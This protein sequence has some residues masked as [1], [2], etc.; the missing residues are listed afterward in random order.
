MGWTPRSFTTRA[1]ISL[2][3]NE[4]EAEVDELNAFGDISPTSAVSLS[5]GYV[6]QDGVPHSIAVGGGRVTETI[7]NLRK[8]ATVVT[9]RGVT[10]LE[11]PLF[12]IYQMRFLVPPVDPKTLEVEEGGV[13]D[14]KSTAYIPYIIGTFTAKQ[15]A[16]MAGAAAWTANDYT[17]RAD[18]TANGRLID[19]LNQLVAPFQ[20]LEAAKSDIFV[21]G[22][23]VV[24]QKRGTRAFRGMGMISMT[25]K[26]AR[27]SSLE[28][29]KRRGQYVRKVVLYGMP[30]MSTSSSGASG[31]PPEPFSYIEGEDY[32]NTVQT[33]S[34]GGV[35]TTI[36]ENITYRTPERVVKAVAKTIS[37][38]PG[39]LV[40]SENTTN[41]W[42]VPAVYSWKLPDP[43][44][45]KSS[46]TVYQGYAPGDKEKMF[47]VVKEVWVGY[48]YDGNGFLK[49]TVTTTAEWDSKTG[50]MKTSTMS[51]A[52]V[53]DSGK[54]QVTRDTVDFKIDSK[55]E[56]W[57]PT[58]ADTTLSA[59]YRPGGPLQ[60]GGA[61][62]EGDPSSGK[63]LRNIVLVANISSE[64]DAFDIE[65]SFPF[66]DMGGLSQVLANLREG[67]GRSINE[68]AT[69]GVGIPWMVVGDTLNLT[70]VPD[71]SVEGS[72]MIVD[73]TGTYKETRQEAYMTSNL[74][75]MAWI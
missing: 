45:L 29:R 40:S 32:A 74:K 38:S 55:G 63:G 61:L 27:I 2:P 6:D 4:F 71:I 30:I 50:K 51:A 49:N 11:N 39:G 28:V 25:A 5:A 22:N 23:L 8:D 48:E 53:R 33:I 57:Y 47:R 68:L 54:L 41:E 10:S 18:F 19:I 17:M 64:P 34:A 36:A 69:F 7:A 3:S 35:T 58:A 62:Y 14:P 31:Q 66:M 13:N 16:M 20:L 43:P 70:E 46:H 75:G 52:A 59:G 21:Y 44:R 37:T 73:A 24:V 72:Y 56:K 67:N 26:D 9:V 12:K 1:N 42:E 65:A 15:I 60:A